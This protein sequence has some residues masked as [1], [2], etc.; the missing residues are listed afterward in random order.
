LDGSIFAFGLTSLYVACQRLLT[1]FCLGVRIEELANN[2]GTYQMNLEKLSKRVKNE[3]ETTLSDDLPA[4]ERE[5]IL[6]I[7][8]RAL[9]DASSRTHREMK[10]TAVVCC[11]PE[12]D[13]AHKIQE[14]MDK[15]RNVLIA[16]LMSIR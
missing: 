13:L 16:N 7:V 1:T 11:G 3:L 5:A 4:A 8:Q 6:E 2:N 15:K 9:L 10:E 12:A 14:E